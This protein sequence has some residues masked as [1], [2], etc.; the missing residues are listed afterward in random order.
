MCLNC[1]L[2]WVFFIL[3]PQCGVQTSLLFFLESHRSRFLLELL[4]HE[5]TNCVGCLSRVT[6]VA[7]APYLRKVKNPYYLWGFSVF[8]VLFVLFPYPFF[9]TWNPIL[10]EL[11][12]LPSLSYIF[13]FR[14]G[15]DGKEGLRWAADVLS[16]P[17]A[18]PKSHFFNLKSSRGKI[19]AWT[20][21]LGFNERLRKNPSFIKRG[22]STGECI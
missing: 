19:P 7:C 18:T 20:L 6:K 1:L 16:S 8:F 3:P 11:E 10:K 5:W 17:F 9:P 14:R 15:W 2:L 21:F 12:Q 13:P 4:Q 22:S